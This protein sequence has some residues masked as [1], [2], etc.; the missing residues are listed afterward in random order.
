MIGRKPDLRTVDGIGG[1]IVIKL[2]SQRSAARAKTSLRD[3][4]SRLAA[5]STRR[6]VS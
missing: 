1:A 6:Q 5:M 3:M 2:S 4:P